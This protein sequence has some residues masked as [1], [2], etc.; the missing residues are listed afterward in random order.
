MSKS[1][2]HRRC[3]QFPGHVN[4]YIFWDAP[5]P[6]PVAL[7][8]YFER[9]IEENGF[10]SALVLMGE[11]DPLAPFFL[12]Q[13]GRVNIGYRTSQVDSMTGKITNG[14]K[15]PRMDGLVSGIVGKQLANRISGDRMGTDCAQVSGL[16]GTREADG[17]DESQQGSA[18]IALA[19]MPSGDNSKRLLK[20]CWIAHVSCQLFPVNGSV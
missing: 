9:R 12:R 10:R 17:D 8:A 15:H 2:F 7:Q 20:P 5:V 6:L 19:S 4:N 1:F 16:A 11:F 14:C 3:R 13:A 18:M